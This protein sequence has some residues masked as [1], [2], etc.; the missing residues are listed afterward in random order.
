MPQVC[1]TK[2]FL[3]NNETINIKKFEENKN[4][5]VL[6]VILIGNKI[7]TTN[8]QIFHYIIILLGQP[9]FRIFLIFGD[10]LC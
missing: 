8:Y 1:K 5:N 6:S 2:T 9:I 10:Q 7:P 3:E 4:L